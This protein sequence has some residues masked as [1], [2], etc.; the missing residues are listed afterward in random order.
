M[1]RPTTEA[2]DYERFPL[3]LPRDVMEALRAK[4]AKSG[5]PINTELIQAIRRGLRLPACAK[6]AQSKHHRPIPASSS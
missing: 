5:A 3:R 6:P 4:S 1:P 2:A